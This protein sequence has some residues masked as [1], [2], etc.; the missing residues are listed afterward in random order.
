MSDDP[1]GSTETVRQDSRSY[2]EILN[3]P[4]TKSE[5]K[6]QLRGEATLG[7]AAVLLLQRGDREAVELLLDVENAVVERDPDT[8]YDSDLWLEVAPE[9]RARFTED[10]VDKLRQVCVEVADRRGLGVGWV[11]VREVLPDVGPQWREQVRE[12]LT[13]KRPTNQGRR[14]RTS[15]PRYVED[16]LAF[17]NA[18]ELTVYR[19]LKQIQEKD[20]PREDTI[21]IYPLA[22][23]RVPG[24][25]WE[26]DVLVTYKGRAGVL[27]VDGPHH[28]GR[29]A[30]DNTRDHLLRDAGIAFVDR[31]PVEALSNPT[32]L[33]AVLRRFLRRLEEAR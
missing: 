2:E 9:H 3:D 24:H 27:E 31:V 32:E 12:Q 17:T 13:G 7:Y 29:K 1:W 18:G 33:T 6:G 11:D 25:T 8:G 14:V 23:G 16:R 5:V 20:L 22:G 10:V 26:P 28:N 15:P 19:A 21:G 30:L 4:W